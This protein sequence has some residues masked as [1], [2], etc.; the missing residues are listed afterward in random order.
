MGYW[1]EIQIRN[2]ERNFDMCTKNICLDC[3]QNTYLKMNI[4]IPINECECDYCHKE[5]EC[6][7]V[8]D[9]F[10][11]LSDAISDFY[12]P[13]GNAL[14]WDSAEGGFFGVETIDSYDLVYD[15]LC[16]GGWLFDSYCE[17]EELVNDIN[18]CIYPMMWCKVDPFG[19]ELSKE[20]IYSWES[21][22]RHVK[23]KNQ[24][25]CQ[26][27][28]FYKLF[29][30]IIKNIL[31]FYTDL[32]IDVNIG[33]EFYRSRVNKSNLKGV[34]SEFAA[35]PK[36][37]AQENRMS[38][39]GISMFYCSDNKD[40]AM[41][42]V[43]KKD[44]NGFGVCKFTNSENIKI[45]DLTSIKKI[46]CFNLFDKEHRKYNDSLFFLRDLNLDLTKQ[47]ENPI[48]YVPTQIFTEV[49]RS[50]LLDNGIQVNGI[51]Y[52]SAKLNFNGKNYVLFYNYDDTK[53]ETLNT[54]SFKMNGVEIYWFDKY[55]NM[56]KK[57]IL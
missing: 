53:N 1:K 7:C 29:D 20:M 4:D 17:N 11:L 31:T 44:T 6:I 22:C 46:G 50:F 3:L 26:D 27:D 45:L 47:I 25:N 19:V 24:K 49:V 42:E 48:D 18:K 51:A 41:A 9:Y 2:D 55:K 34:V 36:E 13:A 39:K 14:S 33:N 37:Y 32:I 5:K 28:K 43:E 52:D 16:A 15:V 10:D 40:I 35:P 12:E 56:I 30:Y 23:T 21:F 38:A 57:S 54:N 8:D